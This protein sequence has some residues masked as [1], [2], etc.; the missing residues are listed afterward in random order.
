MTQDATDPV[1]GRAVY[2]EFVKGSMTTQLLLMPQGEASSHRVVPM[3]LFRRRVSHIQP[4]KT[5]RMTSAHNLAA[6]LIARSTEL[7]ATQVSRDLLLFI[8]PVMKALTTNNWEMYKD[9]IVVEVTASDLE[10]AR[11]GKTPYKVIG[12]VLKVRKALG[13]PKDVVRKPAEV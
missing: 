11:L 8:D 2:L 7:D 1:A 4:R 5:W 3:T 12:R 9:P 10:Q 13:F 6:T